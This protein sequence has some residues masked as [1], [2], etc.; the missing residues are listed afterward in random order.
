M[1]NNLRWYKI[2]FNISTKL[3]CIHLIIFKGKYEFSWGP[4]NSKNV[5][6]ESRLNHIGKKLITEKIQIGKR[7]EMLR[8]RRQLG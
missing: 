6:C 7:L 8:A 3:Q 5:G 2:V 4:T 1:N